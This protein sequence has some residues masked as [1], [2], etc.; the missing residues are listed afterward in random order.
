MLELGLILRLIVGIVVMECVGL[1]GVSGSSF[2]LGSGAENIVLLL[3]ANWIPDRLSWHCVHT[4]SLETL[5][6]VEHNC[7]SLE[8]IHC[9]FLK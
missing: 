9:D 4:L 5:L 1:Y 6:L 8:P 7:F 2:H 3:D